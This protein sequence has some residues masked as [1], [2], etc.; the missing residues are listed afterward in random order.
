MAAP[1][2]RHAA[3]VVL[4]ATLMLLP[5]AFFGLPNKSMAGAWRVLQGELVY[6][7]FWTIYAPGSFYAIAGLLSL[8]GKHVLVPAIAAV[9]LRGLSAGLFFALARRLGAGTLAA[10]GLALLVALS[11][12]EVAPEL[13]TYVG[14]LPALL[15]ALL[16]VAT[17]LQE[18]GVQRIFAAGLVLGVGATFKH[19]V[20]AFVA[21][22]C[23]LALVAAW[24]AAG[25]R[26]PAV[27]AHPWRTVPALFAGCGLVV[28]PAISLLAW[29]AGPAA[30]ND[31]I[32]FPAGD[33]RLV[34]GEPYPSLWPD[35]SFARAWLADPSDLAAGRDAGIH[36]SRWILTNAPQIAFAAA[37]VFVVL[38]R[39]VL[40]PDR[41]ALALALLA[42]LPLFWSAAHV[43]Q[44]THLL[45]MAFCSILL[46]VIAWA[47]TSASERG[48][49][50][51][52][53]GLLAAWVPGLL[54]APVLSALLPLRVWSGWETLD[55]A[56]ARGVLVS[57]REKEI[58]ESVAGYVHANVPPGE[59][60]HVGV[61]RGD[62]IVVSNTRFYYLVDR[63]AATRYQELHPGVTDVRA[64]QEE[65]IADLLRKDVR[66]VV[67]WWFGGRD[68]SP[69][70]HDEIV[71]R[72][73]RLGIDGIGS[74]LFDEFV[75]EHYEPVLEVD[76]YTVLWRRDAGSE[77]Q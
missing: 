65:M 54:V 73:A 60:I 3:F 44:N 5:G 13:E 58:Y 35:L 47:E 37:L 72:R 76:E 33:F 12:F 28:V 63:P 34:R 43:Q 57:P 62:A 70:T 31:L 23:S 20:A 15:G 68:R 9:A 49:R 59:A 53:G 40:R 56:V 71:R 24:I 17:Y 77:P 50:L 1:N 74:T 45:S 10:W 32:A 48:W 55:L 25:R 69:A 66:C 29:K 30:W 11:Q 14:A 18:G 41:L 27:W 6:R 42:A 7:D 52:S 39:R 36:G 75:A 8:F 51:L 19:D 22:A 64:V 2:R 21:L 4:V 61:V 46:G 16:L 38:R 67:L 26:R